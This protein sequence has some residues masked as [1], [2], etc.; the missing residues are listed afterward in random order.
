MNNGKY[1]HD[2]LESVK[3]ESTVLKKLS[4]TII[5]YAN[6]TEKELAEQIKSIDKGLQQ[7]ENEKQFVVDVYKSQ[8]CSKLVDISDDGTIRTTGENAFT[9]ED[10]SLKE[11]IF[12]QLYFQERQ[13]TQAKFEEKVSDFYSDK[14]TDFKFSKSA[15]TPL[16]RKKVFS[17]MKVT[18]REQGYAVLNSLEE[19]ES[20]ENI[21][22]QAVEA[23]KGKQ[24]SFQDLKSIY[25][26]LDIFYK[27]NDYTQLYV[28]D[29]QTGKE[30]TDP[31]LVA[32]GRFAAIWGTAAGTKWMA[33]EEIKGITYAFN[34]SSERVFSKLGELIGKSMTEKGTIDTEAVYKEIS[35]DSYK[36]SEEIARTLL[37]N[38][39]SVKI[40]Y[41]FYKMQN[42]DAKLE[43]RLA[44]S[45]NE[46]LYGF[47]MQDS[48]VEDN[49]EE[50]L[51]AIP[52]FDTKDSRKQAQEQ[53]QTEWKLVKLPN[54]MT[55][56]VPK[57]QYEETKKQYEENLTGQRKKVEKETPKAK[58]E[59]EQE[60]SIGEVKK[61][62]F[63]SK[64]A[65]RE[66]Q[67]QQADIQARQKAMAVWNRSKQGGLSQEEQRIAEEN[68]RQVNQAIVQY[69]NMEDN[70]RQKR[71]G[72]GLEM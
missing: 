60:I 48:M 25:Q 35:G 30:I 15:D 41:D 27:D 62:I 3:D 29:R 26:K 31:Q 18:A 21:Q 9:I 39:A 52:D 59:D 38:P 17:A 37:L 71:N 11:K 16:A 10:E 23:Q 50:I 58:K 53:T 5:R 34:D 2:I 42:D 51:K 69:R 20:G 45:A 33:D 12:A 46:I 8:D 72:N 68:E 14:K 70:R 54:G 66:G 65:T 47:S 6:M 32:M 22:I 56:Q 13:G 57:N 40:V 43:T 63:D 19:C 36:H 55:V 64:I 49:A 1:L 4:E 44:K 61:G 28:K 67:S 24:I 7:T